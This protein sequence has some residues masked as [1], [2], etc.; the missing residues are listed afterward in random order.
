MNPDKFTHVGGKHASSVTRKHAAPLYPIP[1][2]H[3]HVHPNPALT[4]AFEFG[5]RPIRN[6]QKLPADPRKRRDL[7]NLH[8][9]FKKKKKKLDGSRLP[10]SSCRPRGSTE[11]PSLSFVLLVHEKLLYIWIWIIIYVFIFIYYLKFL[12]ILSDLYTLTVNFLIFKIS[13]FIIF[14]FYNK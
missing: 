11:C 6:G 2:S 3:S 12:L 4:Q 7:R 14:F 8:F 1:L 13:K 10:T 5:A 9:T